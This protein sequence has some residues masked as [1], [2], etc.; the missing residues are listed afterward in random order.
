MRKYSHRFSVQAPLGAVVEFHQ[1]SRA[2]K[3]L[4]PPPLFVTFNKVEP[5]AEGSVADFTM[6]LGPLPIHWVATH[7]GVDPMH[8]FSDSQTTGPFEVWIH[9]HS[10]ESLDDNNTEIVDQ[11]QAKPSNHPFW[12][13]VS[14]I[15][16]LSL[17]VLFVYRSR[18]TRRALER[19]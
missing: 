5:L 6:W 2:L 17:P 10:F 19:K 1:D 18:Q 16:W 7:S 15:M 11:I 3:L 4:T 8:G 9:R 13:I 14:R 12:G